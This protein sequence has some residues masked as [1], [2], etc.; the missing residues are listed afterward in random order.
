MSFLDS[1]GE[2][3]VIVFALQFGFLTLRL[4]CCVLTA[5]GQMQQDRYKK[6]SVSACREA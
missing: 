2:Y 5:L 4:R 6:A 3:L 1:L